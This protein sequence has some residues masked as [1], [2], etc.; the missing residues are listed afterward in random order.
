MDNNMIG[1]ILRHDSLLKSII[2]EGCVNGKIGRGNQG[3]NIQS[4]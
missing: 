2:I 4:G 3:W 1:H